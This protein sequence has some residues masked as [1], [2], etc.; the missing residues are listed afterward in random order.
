[1]AL[2]VYAILIQSINPFYLIQHRLN[3]NFVSAE[4]IGAI[5]IVASYLGSRPMING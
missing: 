1:M 2:Q 5:S 3:Y 4:S